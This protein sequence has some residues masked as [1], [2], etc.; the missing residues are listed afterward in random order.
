[1]RIARKDVL[2][3]VTEGVVLLLRQRQKGSRDCCRVPRPERVKAKIRSRS[4]PLQAL[5]FLFLIRSTHQLGNWSS[6]SPLIQSRL[7]PADAARQSSLEARPLS[8]IAS[9]RFFAAHGAV[10]QL[11]GGELPRRPPERLCGERPRSRWQCVAPGGLSP[12]TPFPESALPHRSSGGLSSLDR[13][14]Q[15]ASPALGLDHV[16]RWPPERTDRHAPSAGEGGRFLSLLCDWGVLQRSTRNALVRG[17]LPFAASR[18]DSRNGTAR[19][20]R[21]GRRRGHNFSEPPKSVVG[22]GPSRLEVRR[23]SA[24]Q[25]DGL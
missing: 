9:P 16:R 12:A 13:A 24:S 4:R 15:D 3:Q 21:A 23:R 20:P 14:G 10:G 1:M 22:Y 11:L 19:S 6:G 17:T 2:R 18:A 5:P 25:L 7:V 8:S